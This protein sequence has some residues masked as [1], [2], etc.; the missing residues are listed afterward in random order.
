MENGHAWDWGGRLLS[1]GLRWMR[2]KA[3]ISMPEGLGGC[4]LG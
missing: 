3:G 2:L 4:L 1:G